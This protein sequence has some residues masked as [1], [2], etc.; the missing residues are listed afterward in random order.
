[1]K[2]FIGIFISVFA[3]FLM[4]HNASAATRLGNYTNYVSGGVSGLPL[5]W[6][7]NRDTNI[8]ASGTGSSYVANGQF[9][10]NLD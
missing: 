3:V 10:W 2:R 5:S 7:Y 6:Q 1:M 8:T 4:S 9:G